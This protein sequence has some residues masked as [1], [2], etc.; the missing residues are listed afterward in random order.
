MSSITGSVIRPI[1]YPTHIINHAAT[2]KITLNKKKCTRG[3]FMCFF[4][5]SLRQSF[6]IA[7]LIQCLSKSTHNASLPKEKKLSRKNWHFTSNWFQSSLL[8]ALLK[9]I[10]IKTNQKIKKFWSIMHLWNWP[11]QLFTLKCVK[12]IVCYY[13]ASHLSLLSM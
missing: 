11:N 5:S 12:K 4:T 8:C 13:L 3:R 10:S 6:C 7:P 2:E 1:I 9:L